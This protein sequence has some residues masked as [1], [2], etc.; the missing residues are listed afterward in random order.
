MSN[1][2]CENN[3]FWQEKASPPSGFEQKKKKKKTR[4]KP[5]H[6]SKKN[7]HNFSKKA[8]FYII[9]D[10]KGVFCLTLLHKISLFNMFITTNYLILSGVSDILNTYIF[11][12]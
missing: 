12:N 9:I 10:L 1:A 3:S 4:K 6:I 8:L 7:H 5:H 2:R 11:T